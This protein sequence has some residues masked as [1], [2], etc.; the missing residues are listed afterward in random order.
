MA[1]VVT[2]LLITYWW[3]RWAMREYVVPAIGPTQGWPAGRYREGESVTWVGST[4]S[5]T[6]INGTQVFVQPGDVG[7]VVADDLTSRGYR[8]LTVTFPATGPFT[9]DASDIESREG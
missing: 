2:G 1:G 9:C 5:E 3:L 7:E 8:E 6:G 4:Y